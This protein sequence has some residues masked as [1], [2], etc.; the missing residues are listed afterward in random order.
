VAMG[1]VKWFNPTKDTGVIRPDSG[2]KG[3]FVR[4]IQA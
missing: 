2:R 4:A 1:A 3:G